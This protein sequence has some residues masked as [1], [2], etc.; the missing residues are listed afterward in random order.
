MVSYLQKE[1]CVQTMI[2]RQPQ[3]KTAEKMQKYR[4]SDAF[5]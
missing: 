1:L 2:T 3:K 5:Q 4:T